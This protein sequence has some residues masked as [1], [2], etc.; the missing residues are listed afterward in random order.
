MGSKKDS[1]VLMFAGIVVS[2]MVMIAATTSR[3]M[4][5]ADALVQCDY[6]FRI[7]WLLSKVYE[8]ASEIDS[9]LFLVVAFKSYNSLWDLWHHAQIFGIVLRADQN[10]YDLVRI[11]GY[12]LLHL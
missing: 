3:K 6:S 9:K 5:L 10:F 4:S 11:A 2:M 7:M 8:V 1:I 12:W